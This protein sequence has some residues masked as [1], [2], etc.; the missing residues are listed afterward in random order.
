MLFRSG[1]EAEEGIKF[2]RRVLRGFE[3]TKE[4]QP[5]EKQDVE[6]RLTRRDLSYWS[7]EK[8]MWIMPM[9]EVMVGVG[10]SSRNVW[11]SRVW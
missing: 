10:T 9:G 8:A 7:T 2:P 5:G 6:I 1:F 4:L 11:E 3:K